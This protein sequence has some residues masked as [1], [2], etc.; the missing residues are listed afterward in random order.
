MLHVVYHLCLLCIH[1]STS[2]QRVIAEKLIVFWLTKKILHCEEP[3]LSFPYLLQ[4][5]KIEILE[6]IK[7]GE[8]NFKDCN[9]IS[10]IYIF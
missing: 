3:E 5:N 10:R 2:G 8:T 7:S 4:K 9:L 1:V 6:S